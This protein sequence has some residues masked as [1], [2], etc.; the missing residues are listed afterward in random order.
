VALEA[1]TAYNRPDL[2]AR[3]RR[4]REQVVDREV[5]VLV[6]GEFKQGKSQLV[7]A[8]VNARVCPVDADIATSVP[9]VVRYSR[10]TTASL[11]R[12]P[13]DPT[14][15]PEK[16]EI[17][18]AQLAE[19]V[20]EAANPGN[21]QRVSHAEI[22][23]HRGILSTGLV[24]VD[25]PGV[26][27]LGSAHGAITASALPTADAVLMVS[28]A[29]REYS[30][31]E[32]E[33]LQQATQL[34]PAVAC[35]L[36]K[37]DLYPQWRRI[38]E[39][40]RALLANGGIDAELLAVSSALRMHAVDT[41][42]RELNTESGFPVLFSYVDQRVL[43]ESARLTRDAVRR[44]VLLVTEQLAATMRTE[45][46]MQR[47]GGQAT[48]L[49]DELRAAE[50][51]LDVLS[52]RS[53]RW[54]QTLGDGITDLISDI[55]HDLRDRMRQIAKDAEDGLSGIDLTKQADQFSIWVG[56]RVAAAASA[57]V[58]W[59][60]QRS[61]WLAHKVAEHF[62]SEGL[63]AMPD[64]PVQSPLELASLTSFTL[65]KL[66]TYRLGEKLITG[67]RG[68][69]G[70]TLMVGMLGTVAGLAM[71]NPLSITAGLLL[72]GKTVYDER[73]RLMQRRQVDVMNAVRKHIDEVIFQV[74]KDS[75]DMLRTVQRTLR[76]NFGGYAEEL[77]RSVSESLLAAQNAVT[78][79]AT[80]R[81]Q[82]VLDLEAELTRLDGLA[83][84]AA[85]L[86][87]GVAVTA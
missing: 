31:T 21:V 9:T 6:V 13:L 41:D 3:L 11:V 66:E 20:C 54:Q 70:G 44:E 71:F 50:Q 29:S 12:Q 19:Y 34:C 51:R 84:L 45:L 79:D 36:T 59:A 56:Q 15:P 32:L 80:Q 78:T 47:G 55:D 42:D 82:R 2:G 64:L 14:D 48:Q 27:G 17:A 46:V 39:L 68:G 86:D 10:T 60:V 33:F 18:V 30:A 23:I 7:N 81:G 43:A 26:G 1:T 37:I 74:G 35:V 5:R 61:R 53:A 63:K 62:A 22:G 75:R 57:N 76:D 77:H 73:K 24:L 28:D 16:V 83:Q 69:Y 49:V 87:V 58:V 25:T 52:Q 40:D 85:A 67:M 38:A 8:L 65:P 72:G 4:R